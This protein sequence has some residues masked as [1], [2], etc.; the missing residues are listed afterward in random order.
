MF[1]WWMMFLVLFVYVE[2][3]FVGGYYYVIFVRWSMVLF[4][5]MLVMVGCLG[6][7]VVSVWLC[8]MGVFG[9]VC[10]LVD[11]GGEVIEGYELYGF[12]VIVEGCYWQGDLFVCQG[13]V[14][15]FFVQ[16]VKLVFVNLFQW[17]QDVVEDVVD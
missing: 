10:V 12:V 8:L 1:G 2:G 14:E 13:F 9:L 4:F 5:M 15:V 6:C 7:D 11:V 3:V 17:Y 16:V